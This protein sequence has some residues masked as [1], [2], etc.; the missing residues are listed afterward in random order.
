LEQKGEFHLNEI[1]LKQKNYAPWIILLTIVLNLVIVVVFFMPK[2]QGLSHLDLTL[3]PMMNAIFNSFTFIFLCTALYFVKK[4]NIVYHR[5]F[6]FASFTSTLLFLVTYLAYHIN[7]EST[8]Y[9]GDGAL[10][11]FYYFILITHIVL[12]VPTVLLALWTAAY[13]LN[14]QTP[15][16][17]KIARITLPLWLYVSLTG[18]L[19]YLLISPY[20]G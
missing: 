17:R 11:Y 2:Y 14:R 16:H 12:A 5:R 20:Y 1:Q 3:L 9:G 18:V 15:K 19:V 6:I 10:K 8:P 7:A 4:K 13:G